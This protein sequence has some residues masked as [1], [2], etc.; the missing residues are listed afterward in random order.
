MHFTEYD[1]RLAAYGLL[2][3]ED[4][5]ILLTWFRGNVRSEPCWTLP[6]GGVELD[7]TLRAAVVREVFE[8]TGYTVR[9]GDVLAESHVAVPAG[10][11]RRPMRSQRFLLAATITGGELGTTEV[12]GSTEF[13][14][15]VPIGDLP[16]LRPR[17][18]IIDVA[19][20]V[21]GHRR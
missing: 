16:S 4:G 21:L 13:A 3:S 8:E 2:T 17:A 12:D 9:A 14:R 15:W 19:L 5:L 10:G 6:G 11:D 18:D 7:E 1:V 20:S